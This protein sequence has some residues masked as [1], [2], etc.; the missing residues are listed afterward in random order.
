[1]TRSTVTDFQVVKVTPKRGYAK[2]VQTVI[3]LQI[4]P[5]LGLK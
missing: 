1:M 3:G 4:T 5:F 2:K